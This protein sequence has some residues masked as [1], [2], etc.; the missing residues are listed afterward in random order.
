MNAVAELSVLRE[1][2]QRYRERIRALEEK[3]KI[4]Q[5]QR[6]EDILAIAQLITCVETE[7]GESQETQELLKLARGR[8]ANLPVSA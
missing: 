6:Q 4:L 1:K 7:L 5:E 2:I 8:L 3:V